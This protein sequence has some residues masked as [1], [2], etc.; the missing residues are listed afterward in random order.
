MVMGYP[1]DSD[2]ARNFSASIIG[3]LTA[4]S[5]ITSALMAKNLGAFKKYEINKNYMLKVIR[6]HARVAK[7]I[8][9]DYEG[10][11]YTPVEVNH[12]ILINNGLDYISKALKELWNKALS[13]GE[14]YGYRKCSSISY[15]PNRNY[16]FC[17]GLWSHFY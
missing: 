13:L 9:S 8:D 11:D 7:A 16:F 1:Y 10:L 4:S 6:N 5:Y 12:E 2:E 15:S 17:N 14:S 3:I